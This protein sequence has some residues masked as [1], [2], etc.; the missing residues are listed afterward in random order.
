MQGV[1]QNQRSITLTSSLDTQYLA[2]FMELKKSIFPID[3]SAPIPK[4]L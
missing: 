2:T 3:N 1:E 4:L